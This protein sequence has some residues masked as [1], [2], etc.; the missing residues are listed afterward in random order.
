MKPF[1][2]PLILIVAMGTYFITK[3][4]W[5]E[6]PEPKK[7]VKLLDYQNDQFGFSLKYPENFV[8][9]KIKEDDQKKDPLM[10][11]LVRTDPPT[12][13]LVWK[14]G[15]GMVESLLKKPLLEYLK[16]NVERKYKIDYK[17]FKLEKIEDAKLGNQDGFIAWFTFQDPNKKYREKIKLIATTKDKSGWYIQCQAP[18]EMW[19]EAEP[20]CDAIKESFQFK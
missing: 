7:E 1:I 11:K 13:I 19:S 6:K 15:L 9:G 18:T 8:I 4:P 2:I 20:A 5:Q 14:E 12:L 16:E 3:K 17:D 10:A